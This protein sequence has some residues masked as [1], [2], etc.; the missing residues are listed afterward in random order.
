[1][2]FTCAPHS[3]PVGAT[4][5]KPI[6]I[7]FCTDLSIMFQIYGDFILGDLRINRNLSHMLGH[8][9]AIC[10]RKQGWILLFSQSVW[11]VNHLGVIQTTFRWI[12]MDSCTNIRGPQRMN[13]TVFGNTTMR[14]TIAVSS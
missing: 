1:M 13:P 6:P 10:G 2:K 4:V 11:S 7:L 12:A 8:L 5:E 3:H 9:A 14:L